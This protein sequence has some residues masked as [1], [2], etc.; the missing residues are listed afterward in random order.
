MHKARIKGSWGDAN[1]G[2][3]KVYT[4]LKGSFE[5]FHELDHDVL[6]KLEECWWKVNIHEVALFTRWENF[7]QGTYANFKTKKAYDPY[8]YVNRIFG[9]NYEKSNAG[10]TQDNQWSDECRINPTHEPLVCKIKRFKM[11]KYSFNAD[12]EYIVIK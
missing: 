10:S 12:K 1:P 5:N 4:W 7:G 3:I 11:M 6:I 9:R 2:V 8:L